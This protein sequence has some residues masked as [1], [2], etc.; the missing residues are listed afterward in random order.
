MMLATCTAIRD[1]KL[2]ACS[3]KLQFLYLSMSYSRFF[4]LL[5][6]NDPELLTTDTFK[7]EESKV[8]FHYRCTCIHNINK[9][10]K[11]RS[12]ILLDII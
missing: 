5:S 3:M 4:M 2:I 1:G 8:C 6:V 9:W 12:M 7:L 11:F 10:S